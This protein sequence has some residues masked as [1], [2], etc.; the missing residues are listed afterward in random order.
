MSTS[1]SI[2][3]SA[4]TGVAALSFS[5][6]FAQSHENGYGPDPDGDSNPATMTRAVANIGATDVLLDPRFTIVTFE[7]PPGAH[8]MPVNDSLAKRY[9]VGFSKGLRW[10][11]C[12][13]QRYYQYDSLCTYIRPPSGS[14]AAYY[15]DDLARPLHVTFN[16]EAVCG[17]I[18]SVYPPGGKEGEIF[19]VTLDAKKAD[20]TSA[21]TAKVNLA[22]TQNTFRWRA[23]AGGFFLNDAATSMDITV[24]REKDQGDVYQFL[25]DDLAYVTKDCE[26]VFE[27]IRHVAGFVVS[28][29]GEIEAK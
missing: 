6:A 16:N 21:G 8:N 9:G 13:D 1:L 19:E 28:D 27:A 5:A 22:W 12:D 15:R 24:A 20:G 29:S 3:L 4:I 25:I 7:P 17:V 10:Q 14:Y 26:E 2:K 18:L 11:I 23:M